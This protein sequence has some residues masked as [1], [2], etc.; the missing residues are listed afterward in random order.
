MA[1]PS[2]ERPPVPYALP[3]G[4]SALPND[5]FRS[6]QYYADLRAL[7]ERLARDEDFVRRFPPQR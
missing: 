7:S 5:Y 4:K 6:E 2:R 3:D 1:P